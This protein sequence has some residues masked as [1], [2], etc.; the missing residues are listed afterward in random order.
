MY[1]LT[2]LAASTWGCTLIRARE[3][4]VKVIRAAMAYGAGVFHNPQ[5]PKVAKALE[6]KQNEGLQKVLGAYR[7]TPIRNLELEAYCAPLDLYFNKRL[8]DFENRLRGSQIAATLDKTSNYI[9]RV[10]KN[11][12]GRP[13]IQK[14]RVLGPNT[15]EWARQWVQGTEKGTTGEALKRDWKK[16]WG[17]EPPHRAADITRPKA[18]QGSHLRVYKGFKKAQSFI[19]CQ[20]RIG[21]IGLR[22]FLFKQG[23]PEVYTPICPCGTGSQTAE[24]LF[25][26][27]EDP[28]SRSLRKLGFHTKEQVWEALSDPKLAKKLAQGLLSS[29]WLQEYRLANKLHFEET[30]E[31]ARVGVTKR[32]PPERHKKRRAHRPLAP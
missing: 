29:G 10:L 21:K 23:V 31:A 17:N 8:A 22:A 18:F 14:T 32:P 24:H 25:Y 30:L 7:A 4:Y 9:K 3:I 1:A 11:K 5:C 6:R 12:K 27:C 26:Q 15:S 20:A 16:R 19:L 2:R 28:R 13:K